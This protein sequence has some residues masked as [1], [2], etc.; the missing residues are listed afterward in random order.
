[1]IVDCRLLIVDW[2]L[3][4]AL[5]EALLRYKPRRCWQIFVTHQEIGEQKPEIVDCQ[6]LILDW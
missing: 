5:A 3:Y 2:E 4:R 1:M 6:L